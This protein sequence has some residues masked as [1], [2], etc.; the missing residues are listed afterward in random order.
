MCE[1][2]AWR[3]C[4]G[5]FG[6]RAR[7]SL[8]EAT[9]IGR[10]RSNTLQHSGRMLCPDMRRVNM[11]RAVRKQV[12]P[13]QRVPASRHRSGPL[14]SI[15]SSSSLPKQASTLGK[16]IGTSNAP[17]SARFS[18]ARLP[19]GRRSQTHRP[20]PVGRTSAAALSVIS[21]AV[22][23]PPTKTNSP[24]IGFSSLA[25]STRRWKLGLAMSRP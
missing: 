2:F 10:L 7:R 17:G 21:K 1:T 18:S 24:R 20:W 4:L 8:G 5:D 9:G 16:F 23:H 3:R 14:L 22:V 12:S 11:S 6:P 19:K 25:A 15:N 13:P